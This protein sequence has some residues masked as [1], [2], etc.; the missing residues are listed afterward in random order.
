MPGFT[1]TQ[2]AAAIGV[3]VGAYAVGSVNFSLLAARLLGHGDLRSHGSGNAGAT[4]LARVAGKG[5]AAVVLALDIARGAGVILAA[6]AAGFDPWSPLAAIPLLLGNMFPVFH[7]L[8]GG[9]GVAAAVGAMLVVSPFAVLAG[10]GIFFAAFAIG[11]RVSAGSIIMAL[12]YPA[13][14]MLLGG[15]C[16]DVVTVAALALLLVASHR[17]NLTR[18]FAG[19]EPRFGAA[20]KTSPE[21][22]P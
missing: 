15:T 13:A 2:I 21:A 3:L 11:R 9:K 20:P 5:P 10:G 22:E 17:R 18:L 4:N 16:I 1:T 6:S 14:T 19:T 12:S 7:N 8:R